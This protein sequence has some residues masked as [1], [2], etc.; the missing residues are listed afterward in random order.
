[1]VNCLSYSMV[2]LVAAETSVALVL[3]GSMVM[4]GVAVWNLVAAQ[5]YIFFC[6]L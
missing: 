4:E 3:L 1:M 2:Y 6:C 5:S